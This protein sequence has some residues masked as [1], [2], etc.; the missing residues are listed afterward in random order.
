MVETAHRCTAVDT[1]EDLS[2]VDA[3][4]AGDA[5]LPSYRSRGQAAP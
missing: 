5:L 3:I 1:P 4:M 2:R